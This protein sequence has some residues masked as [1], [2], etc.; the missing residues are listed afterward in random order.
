V[1]N[2][3]NGKS[4]EGATFEYAEALGTERVLAPDGISGPVLLRFR[5]TDP[6]LIPDMR[7][8]VAGY[9]AR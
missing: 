1:L 6:L 9:V 4:D 2:A 3:A 5:V 8:I 7:L